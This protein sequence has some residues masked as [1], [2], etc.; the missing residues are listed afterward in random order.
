V[1]Y[2]KWL[3][4]SFFYLECLLEVGKTQKLSSKIWQIVGDACKKRAHLG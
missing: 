4:M 2:A 3:E 1:N